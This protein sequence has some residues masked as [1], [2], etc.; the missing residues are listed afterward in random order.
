MKWDKLSV[1]R[2]ICAFITSNISLLLYIKPIINH[3]GVS[4]FL[5]S[6]ANNPNIKINNRSH[7]NA[8]LNT[9]TDQILTRS[10]FPM[11]RMSSTGTSIMDNGIAINRH[12]SVQNTRRC[13]A[14]FGKTLIALPPNRL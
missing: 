5:F 10:G 4:L 6:G 13:I 11:R 12:Y 3:D 14:Y 2:S 9:R 8:W 7:L 1:Q